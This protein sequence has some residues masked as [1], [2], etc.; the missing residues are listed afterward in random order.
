LLIHTDDVA[1]Y[2]DVDP[3]IGTLDDFTELMAALK[4]EGIKVIVDIVP[5]HSSDDH[6]WFQEALKSEKGSAA[7]ERYIFRDG[8]LLVRHS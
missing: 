3:K 6:V 4:A 1:D 8:E 5:N 7:R 2:R